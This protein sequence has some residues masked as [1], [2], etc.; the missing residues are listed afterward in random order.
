[1][2]NKIIR[3]NVALAKNYKNVAGEHFVT[4]FTNQKPANKIIKHITEYWYFL[5]KNIDV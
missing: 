4:F 2:N 1:M 5:W 3:F